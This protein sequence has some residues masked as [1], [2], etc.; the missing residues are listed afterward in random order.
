MPGVGGADPVRLEGDKVLLRPVEPEDVTEDYVAWMN[1]PEVNRFMETRFRTH[2]PESVADFVSRMQADANIYFFAIILKD[3]DRHVGNIKLA[4]SP[5]HSRGEISL[6]IGDKGRWGRGLATEAISL[7]KE[8]GLEGLGLAKLTAGCY[9]NNPGS[10]KAFEK[11]GFERDAVLRAEYVC[12]GRRVDGI[13][14]ACFAEG[15]G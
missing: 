9:A 3:D 4:V 5:E 14:F 13:R 7:I 10:A 2:T 6:F 1:D 8:F 15:K 11:S 12:E